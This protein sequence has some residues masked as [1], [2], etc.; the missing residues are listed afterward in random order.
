MNRL[1][2][3]Y[4]LPYKKLLWAV[5]IFQVVAVTAT[6]TLP[7]LNAMLIDQGILKANTNYIVKIGA[8]MLA[9]SLVQAVFGIAAT[10]AGS[11]AGMGFGRDV[12]DRLFHT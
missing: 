12:R 11:R 7:T 4:L 2:R 3:S 9:L 6:M 8:V 10:W 5:L 1:M